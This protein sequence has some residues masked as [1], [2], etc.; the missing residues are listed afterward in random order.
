[1]EQLAVR[2]NV[3]GPYTDMREM[4]DEVRPDVV[5]IATQPDSHVFLATV[6]LEAGWHVFV[7]KP[8]ALT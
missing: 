3:P 5:H 6:A 1:M 4:L 7:E 8:F 2:M